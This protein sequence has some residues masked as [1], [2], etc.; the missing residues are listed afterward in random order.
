[1]ARLEFY[2]SRQ[3]FLKLEFADAWAGQ[4]AAFAQPAARQQ[5][6]RD[7]ECSASIQSS[8]ADARPACAR[9]GEFLPARRAPPAYPPAPVRPGPPAAGRAAF[10]CRCQ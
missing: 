5:P 4:W 6:V 2:I 8:D 10:P 3:L 1:M 9:R 7:S